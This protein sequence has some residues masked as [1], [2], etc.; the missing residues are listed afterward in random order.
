MKFPTHLVLCS[1]VAAIPGIPS[2]HAQQ[3]PQSGRVLVI[4]REFIKPGKDGAAHEATEAAYIRAAMA[5]KAKMRY[6]A[7]SSFTGPSRALFL[8]DYPSFAAWEAERKSVGPTLGAALDKAN[9]ADGDVLSSTD[10]SVWVRRDDVST[11]VDAPAVGTRFIE[12][13]QYI[14]K[15]GHVHEFEE[16]AKMYTEAAKNVPEMHWTAYQLAYGSVE[17]PTFLIL[18]A[19]KSG[20][21]IDTGMIAGRKFGESLSAE[22]RKKMSEL[23]SDSIASEMTNIFSVNPRMSMPSDGMIASDPDFWRPKTMPT[24]ASKKTAPTKQVATSGQ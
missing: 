24:T 4:Q 17:G 21:E 23:E 19:L 11:N 5:G 8:S 13:S 20:Q 10:A 2:L 9:V 22:Q 14:I 18:T 12:V 15:P 16:L 7:L 3:A 1:L 6:V